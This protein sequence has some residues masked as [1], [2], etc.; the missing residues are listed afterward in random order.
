MLYRIGGSDDGWAAAF[1]VVADSPEQGTAKAKE[2]IANNRRLLEVTRMWW[3]KAQAP[4]E[5]LWVARNGWV[6]D[7][8]EEAERRFGPR[9]DGYQY[10]PDDLVL[11]EPIVVEGGIVYKPECVE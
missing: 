8:A 10:V 7:G 2:W 4:E 1:Y 11:D 3:A 5:G 9:P 6:R